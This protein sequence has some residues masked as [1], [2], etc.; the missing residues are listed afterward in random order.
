MNHHEWF[1]RNVSRACIS[2]RWF[3]SRKKARQ[4][5]DRVS[6]AVGRRIN[7]YRCP[8]CNGWHVT[9]KPQVAAK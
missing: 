8:Y 4:D 9:C 7:V 6:A 2:K 3:P 5:A 1:Q